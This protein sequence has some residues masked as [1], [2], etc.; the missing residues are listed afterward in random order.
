M[1][2]ILNKMLDLIYPPIQKC[3]FCENEL[4][5]LEIQLGLCTHCLNQLYPFSEGD[6]IYRDII[7]NEINY[8][9]VNQ[10][11]IIQ[12]EI[13]QN[14]QKNKNNLDLVYG[15]FHYVGL[16]KELI[17][18]V[19]YYGARQLVYPLV[20]LM[21][22]QYPLKFRE[23]RWNGLV[24]VPMH[25]RRLADRGFNQAFLLAEGLAFFLNLP[26]CDWLVRKKNTVPQNQLSMIERKRNLK[27]AFKLKPEIRL[28]AG[29]WLIID[30]IF[31]TGSTVNE[32]AQIFKEAGAKVVGTFT[33]ARA[34][35]MYNHKIK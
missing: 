8:G 32:I 14:E 15:A 4:L 19:K 29:N 25:K 18:Q 10:S 20:E 27:G 7:Y 1:I 21:V 13:N 17:Y 3:I 26:L 34:S 24:P 22:C 16:I 6:F 11:K 9:E 23:I 31:T 35:G 30:D 5:D 28:G 12:S 2:Q 33:L